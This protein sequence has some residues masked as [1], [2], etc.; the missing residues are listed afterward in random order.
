MKNRL[1]ALIQAT[2]VASSLV[3]FPYA[4]HALDEQPSECTAEQVWIEFLNHKRCYSVGDK[5]PDPYTRDEL[6]IRD[7]Q[8]R[9]L[10]APHDNAQW[11][12]ASDHY[13]MINREN[14]V[15]IEIWDTRGHKIN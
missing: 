8:K 3:A 12:Q 9:K 5:A 6:A 2:L 13:L 4:A 1:P 10:P 15:I 11:V 7:W 14:C